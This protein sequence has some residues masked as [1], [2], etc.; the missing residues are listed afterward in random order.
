MVQPVVKKY[1][2]KWIIACNVAISMIVAI[3]I[4]IGVCTIL[5]YEPPKNLKETIG[6]IAKFKQRDEEWY[7]YIG[8][9]TGNYFNVTFEDGTFF[10]AKGISYDNIDRE[11]F[12]KITVGKE[13]KITYNSSWSRPNRI[14]AIEYNGV[15]YLRLDDVL[16]GYEDTAKIM[17]V[18]GAIVIALPIVVGGIGLFIVNYKYRKKKVQ[19]V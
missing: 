15:D 7:D 12:D 9:P 18:V 11:L 16:A 1:T 8:G 19:T 13:I 3:C 5:S 2:K 6:T 14:Y 10:E 4:I 17:N